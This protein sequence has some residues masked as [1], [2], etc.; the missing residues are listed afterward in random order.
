MIQE[1][2][3]SW[4]HS[5]AIPASEAMSMYSAGAIADLSSIG[6]I[7]AQ[8][9][10]LKAR[11][12]RIY[13]KSK[14]EL[15]REELYERMVEYQESIMCLASSST[16]LHDTLCGIA[17]ENSA[18]VEMTKANM[19]WIRKTVT[20]SVAKVYQA[21]GRLFDRA[22]QKMDEITGLL[23]R[24]TPRLRSEFAGKLRE[25]S[26]HLLELLTSLLSALLGWI[27]RF[28]QIAE[29]KGLR[30][31][32]VIVSLDPL[33]FASVSVFGFSIPV[34]KIKLPKIEMEFS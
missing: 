20:V 10:N 2:I 23:S 8:Q 11:F 1:K 19:D 13:E 28:R 22:T 18:W 15:G 14:R 30:L 21:F 32:K 25:L 33:D 17:E 3:D 31:N 24:W 34:P 16:V 29:E 9:P 6:A 5:G 12:R 4:R 7:K 26:Q 27:S